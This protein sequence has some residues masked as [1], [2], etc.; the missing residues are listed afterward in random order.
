MAIKDLHKITNYVG[1]VNSALH[2]IEFIWRTNNIEL[3]HSVREVFGELK[4]ATY[5]FMSV[6]TE[7][8]DDILPQ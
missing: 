6:I 4:R 8:D 5:S 1:Q 7:N 2:D 3:P